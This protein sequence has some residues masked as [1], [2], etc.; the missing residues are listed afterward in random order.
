MGTNA[1]PTSRLRFKA[2]I[3]GW[4]A[5]RGG[6]F[7]LESCCASLNLVSFKQRLQYSCR[8]I[9][10]NFYGVCPNTVEKRIFIFY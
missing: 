8:A 3:E 1:G 10:S 6:T 2:T 5:Q 4:M 7:C 9:V